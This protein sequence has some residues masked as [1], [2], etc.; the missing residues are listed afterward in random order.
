MPLVFACGTLK[1]GF[2]LHERGLGDARFV[3]V[4]RTLHPHPLLIAGDRFAPMIMREVSLGF[5]RVDGEL[6]EVATATLTKLDRIESVG[7]PGNFRDLTAVEWLDGDGIVEAWVFFKSRALATPI[8]SDCLSAYR[9]DPR[10][11]APDHL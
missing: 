8:H 1:R 9:L 6:F 7:V 10:F 2:P 3:G 5:T 11:V 4:A